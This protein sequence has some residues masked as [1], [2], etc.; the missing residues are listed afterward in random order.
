VPLSE[1]RGKTMKGRP[2]YR[3]KPREPRH[4]HEIRGEENCEACIQ[5][6]RRQEAEKEK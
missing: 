5:E 4:D 1:R 2:K 3:W 6:I